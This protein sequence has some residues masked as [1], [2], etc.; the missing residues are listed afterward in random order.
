MSLSGTQK[1][2]LAIG[3]PGLRY[4]GFTAKSELVVIVAAP[5]MVTPD[6]RT[7]DVPF[8]D[9]NYD[10]PFDDRNYDVPFDDRTLDV[11]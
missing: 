8:D 5:S 7:Y 9:R 3:G 4:A 2:R 6:E 10:V 1:T 11:T